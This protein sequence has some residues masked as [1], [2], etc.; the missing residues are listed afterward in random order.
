M[1]RK[2]RSIHFVGVGGIGMSGIAEVL[3]NLGFQVSG[4]D[5]ADSEITQRLARLGVRFSLGHRPENVQGADVVVISSAVMPDN[6]E[7]LAARERGIPVIPR[8]EMLAELMRMKEGIA[9]AGV[10]GKTTTTSLIAAVLAQGGLDPTAVIGG[11]VKS[12]GSNAHLGEGKFLVAEADESDRSFLKLSP[13]IAVVTTLEEEHLDHYRDLEDIKGTFLRFINQIPFYGL[14]VLCADERH[15]R[16]LLPWVEKPYITYGLTPSSHY[17]AR[18]LTFHR[19]Q[20]SFTAWRADTEIGRIQLQLPGQHNVYNALAALV[21]GMELDI[22]FPM[23]QQALESF[24]G[25]QRRFEI[26]GEIEGVMVVD[27]Y[28]H[29]PTEIRATL[30]AARQGWPEK[31]LIVAFQP[32]RYSRTQALLR[33]FTE[34]FDEADFLVLTRV[35]PAGETPLPGVEADLIYQGI[36]RRGHPP[37][38][39][40]EKKEEVPRLLQQLKQPGDLILTLGAGDIWKVGEALLALRRKAEGPGTSG[41]G[42]EALLAG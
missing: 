19:Q 6:V 10:H 42:G 16:D 12:L 17:W 28:G 38:L 22:P 37:V 30:R 7:V 21:V 20:T 3:L 31:R 4:T 15:L 25:I 32:H 41:R 40:V 27:D 1:F 36:L 2:T 11:K 34:A 14:A 29:H 13:T 24:S 35:Y 5:W 26:K 8:A 23:I 39:Y 18:D 33:E 9:V